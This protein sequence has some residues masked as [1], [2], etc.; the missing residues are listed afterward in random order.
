MADSDS[1]FTSLKAT[2]TEVG[3]TVVFYSVVHVIMDRLF[4]FVLSNDKYNSFS[5]RDR[6]YLAEKICS[7][8]NSLYVGVWSAYV[9]FVQKAYDKDV[10]TPYPKLGHSVLSHL[11]G[12]TI[13]DIATM[14][15]QR[16]KDVS[17]WIHHIAGAYGTG[18]MM[19]FKQASFYPILFGVTEL[20]ASFNN[21]VWYIENV[22][23]QG[24]LHPQYKNAMVLRALSFIAFR[25]W[26]FPFSYYY[27]LKT[28]NFDVNMVWTKI[29]NLHPVVSVLSVL[30]VHMI[31]VL[32]T[33]WTYAVCKLACRALTGRMKPKKKVQ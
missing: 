20:T 19:Y 3:K 28:C 8:I 27:T 4:R 14:I 17:M 22:T 2:A 24:R 29:R 33:G 18:L 23:T 9:I 15:M 26:V 31:G 13:Y 25:V 16:D 6:I 5:R 1:D 7:T 30:N 10:F 32:N 11:F 12:Y 21:L